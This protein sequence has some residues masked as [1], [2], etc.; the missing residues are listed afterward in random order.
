[1][2]GILNYFLMYLAIV[3]SMI[4]Y[5]IMSCDVVIINFGDPS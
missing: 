5:W 1:M 2:K 4:Q 3:D